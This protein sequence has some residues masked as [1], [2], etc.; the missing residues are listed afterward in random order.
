MQTLIDLVWTIA[1]TVQL[2]GLIQLIISII[3]SII[4]ANFY[5]DKD[6]KIKIHILPIIYATIFL[7]LLH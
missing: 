6:T 1:A 3:I 5:P 2:G 4:T 7:I